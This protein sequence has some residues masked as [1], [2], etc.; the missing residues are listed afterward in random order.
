MDSGVLALGLAVRSQPK[1]LCLL[2]QGRKLEI[3]SR[4][5]A[6]IQCLVPHSPTLLHSGVWPVHRVH[7]LPLPPPLELLGQAGPL[8]LCRTECRG[9]C[10]SGEILCWVDEGKQASGPRMANIGQGMQR[11]EAVSSYGQLC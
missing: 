3:A 7:S 1:L 9:L 8:G 10:G 6:R 2:T 4:K 11:A 5:E